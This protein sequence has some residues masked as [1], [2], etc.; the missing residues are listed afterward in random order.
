VHP[1]KTAIEYII[2]ESEAQLFEAKTSAPLT[3]V[4]IDKTSTLDQQQ[5]QNEARNV[6]RLKYLLLPP[7]SQKIFIQFYTEKKFQLAVLCITCRECGSAKRCFFN[8]TVDVLIQ[9]STFQGYN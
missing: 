6:N 8:S 7:H 3:G 2:A 4:R 5:Q 1:A 9:R